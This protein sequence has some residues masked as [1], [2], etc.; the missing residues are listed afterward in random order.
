MSKSNCL[1]KLAEKITGNDLDCVTVRDALNCIAKELSGDENLITP[2][3]C[4]AIDVITEHVKGPGE[5]K[6]YCYVSQESFD[7]IYTTKEMNTTDAGVKWH[8]LVGDMA[9][10][11]NILYGFDCVS[12]IEDG[13]FCVGLYKNVVRLSEFDVLL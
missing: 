12:A 2:T 9:P 5:N 4:K 7:Y 3:I 8:V 11:Q 6:L 1:E 10:N 13:V